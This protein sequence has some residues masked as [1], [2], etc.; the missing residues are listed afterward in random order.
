MNKYIAATFI[1]IFF[2]LAVGPVVSGLLNL[3]ALA[4]GY[5]EPAQ[6]PGVSGTLLSI[7]IGIFY[8]IKRIRRNQPWMIPLLLFRGIIFGC[9]YYS[10]QQIWEIMA[11]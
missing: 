11:I 4:A 10:A 8:A 9:I 1:F 6:W 2:W 5:K 7:A 3:F